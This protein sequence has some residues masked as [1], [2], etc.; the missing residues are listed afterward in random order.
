M[1]SD[2]NKD[3]NTP[4]P[5]QQLTQAKLAKHMKT[6]SKNTNDRKTPLSMAD[7]SEFNPD[8]YVFKKKAKILILIP[9]N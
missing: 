9:K 1:N 8:K 2:S 5:S 7:E 4:R 6:T 3:L